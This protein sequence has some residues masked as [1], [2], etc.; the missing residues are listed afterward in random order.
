MKKQKERPT[1]LVPVQAM[2]S[3]DLCRWVKLE[4]E[5]GGLSVSTYLRVLILR[6][7]RANE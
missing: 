5:K 7:Q 4:A 2:V 1:N 6:E 3:P